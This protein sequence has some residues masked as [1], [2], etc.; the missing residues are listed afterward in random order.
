MDGLVVGAP[1]AIAWPIQRAGVDAAA[2][3]DDGTA[4]AT[5]RRLAAGADGDPSLEIGETGIAAV[6]ALARVCG[7]SAARAA[8]GIGADSDVVVIACEGVTDKEVFD[9]LRG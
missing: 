9:R 2:T 7:A 3:V 1:S 8:I 5:L 4:V 6:A